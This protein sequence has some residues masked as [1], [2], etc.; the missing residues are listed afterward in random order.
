MEQAEPGEH[1]PPH[2]VADVPTDIGAPDDATGTAVVVVLGPCTVLVDGTPVVELSTIQRRILE[3]LA[4]A[5]SA[6]VDVDQ[7]AEAIWG[8]DQP[9]TARTS[10]HNQISRI[11]RRLDHDVVRTDSG[12]YSLSVRTD[13][14]EV[15]AGLA[16]AE[17]RLAAGDAAGAVE[18]SDLAL[19]AWRGTP[20]EDLTDLDDVLSA[21][22]Q[23]AEV[24]RSLENVRLRAA[25]RAG[26]VGWSVPEAERLVAATPHDEDRWVLLMRALEAAG[27][28]GDALGA[29]ERARRSLA[30]HLGLEP[31]R[32]LRDTEAS[33]LAVPPG[34]TSP[35]QVPFVGRAEVIDRV[36]ARV[37][38]G[39][40]V[41]LTGEVGIGKSRVLADV[42]QRHRR[43]GARVAW[44]ACS[45]HPDT[46]IATLVELA[47]ELG[48]ELDRALPP[49]TAFRAA[50]S[51][52]LQSGSMVLLAVDDLDRA[53]P[54]SAAALQDAARLDGVSLVATV[55]DVDLLPVDL[56]PEA[57]VEVG[58]LDDEELREL[59]AVL[60]G[61]PIEGDDHALEWLVTMSGGNPTLVEHLLDDPAPVGDRPDPRD[62]TEPTA[63]LRDLVRERVR[64]LGTT[65][66][67]TLDV[68]AVCG[69]SFPAAL[70]DRLAPGPGRAGA[71]A[72]SLLDEHLDEDGRPWLS[73]RHGAVREILYDDLPP[74]RRMEIH[75][76]VGLLLEQYGAPAPIIAAHALDSV[77][78]APLPAAL[79]AIDAAVAA[80]ADG[81]H[82]DAAQWFGRAAAAAASSGSGATVEV[83]A[84][85][86]RGDSLRL[87]GSEDQETALF[88]AA[89][90]AFELGDPA[91]I[92]DA[93]FAVLQL[94]ATTESGSL[95]GRAIELAGRALEVVTDPDQRALVAAGASLTHSMTG[96]SM[97]CRE[98]FLDAEGWAT[99]SATRRHVLPFA[100][101]ALG[102]PADLERRERLTAALLEL[103]VAADDPVAAFEGQQLAFSVALQRADGPAVRSALA[104]LESL[105]E[106]VGDVG[107]RWAIAYQRS[108][109]AHL[110]AELELAE[111][112]AEDALAIFSSVSPSRAMATYG[113]QLLALRMAQGRLGELVETLEVLLADQPGVPAW[114]AA[115][116]LALADGGDRTRARDLAA[117]ALDDVDEDF[118]WLAAHL[119]GG[120]AAARCDDDELVRRY[121][122]RLQPW[123]GRVC[124]QGTCAYGPVDTVLFLLHRALGDHDA[125]ER[126]R[127]AAHGQAVSLQA[128]V[129][130]A[131]LDPA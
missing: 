122:E 2:R 52:S 70:L 65:T 36:M 7:L 49:I 109:V 35:T 60:R 9:A 111:R 115:L 48:V 20:F 45:E 106:R 21:R 103:A 67:T 55:S 42:V 13:L 39:E 66:R 129:F 82:S 10:I 86:G 77:E 30:E 5:G 46:A 83:R 38:A 84:L 90:A 85:I 19:A 47:A 8:D 127:V 96:E 94:G 69:A 125:A 31:G 126:H 75:H 73:F 74:G 23:L 68:A 99:S 63:A 104:Q 80:T 100:Y 18:S 123:S 112:H 113:G 61:R 29:Y 1:D 22:R 93:A 59:A 107:R 57:R 32:A 51:A 16:R 88:T 14:D 91:L 79:R 110:D 121:L 124:W 12:R 58:P 15:E 40:P 71:V 11:R 81:A 105:V 34:A 98:L 25:L 117:A 28:R 102:H 119:I 76:Q 87:A 131:E 92:G 101:L 3:R 6:Q 26:Q 128:P 89:D 118:T 97:R 24:R 72:A 116:A 95:H 33:I 4:L 27:R 64:R 114:N 78:V 37:V 130:G 120:R 108:A 44:C 41:V 43:T 54:T 53:G 62:G 56:H 17:S 50:V